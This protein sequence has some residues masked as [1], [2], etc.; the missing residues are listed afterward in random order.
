LKGTVAKV[1]LVNPH[2]WIWID[3]KGA[4]GTVTK[5]GIEGGPPQRPRSQRHHQGH[6]QDR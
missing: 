4:D 2:G 1:E 6:A 3:V 5:W